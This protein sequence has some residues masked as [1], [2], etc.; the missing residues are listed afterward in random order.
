M[1]TTSAMAS[2]EFVVRFQTTFA[3]RAGIGTG[4]AGS[5]RAHRTGSDAVARG[6]PALGQ[7]LGA[8]LHQHVNEIAL[9]KSHALQGIGQDVH[10]V[11]KLAIGQGLVIKLEIGKVRVACHGRIQIGAQVHDGILHKISCK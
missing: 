1:A 6:C 4:C 10:L 9:L 11:A 3:P 8:V 2:S 7:G 5:R